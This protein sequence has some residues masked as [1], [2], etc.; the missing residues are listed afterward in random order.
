MH[1]GDESLTRPPAVI[2]E[3][4]PLSPYVYGEPATEYTSEE[5]AMGHYQSASIL[6]EQMRVLSLA[7]TDGAPMD[8]LSPQNVPATPPHI[9]VLGPENSGKT[10]LCKMLINYA[11]RGEP[12][13]H[14]EWSPV[15]VNVDPGD[16]GTLGV[17][18]R[19]IASDDSSTFQGAWS[20]PGSISATSLSTPLSTST[21]ACP[22][23]LSASTAPTVWSSNALIPLTYWYGH[24]EIQR[25][26][27]L[28]ERIIRNLGARIQE[29]LEVD[30]KG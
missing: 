23:G 8:G 12:W 7:I 14:D 26:P 21:S 19:W 29:R 20:V 25:N 11:V 15:L 2:S 22:L 16:V 18:L 9:L 27:V 4:Y 3:P 13:G 1:V 30:S 5:T 17:R 10:T 24:T 6:F 28:L